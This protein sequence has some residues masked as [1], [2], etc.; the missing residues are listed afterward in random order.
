VE[1]FIQADRRKTIN[2]VATELECSHGLAYSIM[3]DHFEVLESVH[4]VGAQRT[5]GSRKMN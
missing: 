3:H 2:S 4:M 1:K 5:E